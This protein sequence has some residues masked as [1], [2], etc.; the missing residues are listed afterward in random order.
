MT[1]GI[2]GAVF[3]YFLIYSFILKF[4]LNMYNV[5]DSMLDARVRAKKNTYKIPTLM[6]L[7]GETNSK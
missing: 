2:K 6:E 1:H 7:M 5:S 4:L 3:I